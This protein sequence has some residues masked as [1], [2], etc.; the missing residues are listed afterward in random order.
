MELQ[1]SADFQKN[2]IEFMQTS[3]LPTRIFGS[4]DSRKGL[5][6]EQLF[7]NFMQTWSA[8]LSNAITKSISE[9]PNLGI[10]SAK[11]VLNPKFHAQLDE[12]MKQ[13][14]FKYKGAPFVVQF[15]PIDSQKSLVDRIWHINPYSDDILLC[16]EFESEEERDRFNK[17]AKS[18]GF[19][20][21][22]QMLQEYKN[23]VMEQGK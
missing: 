11:D 3:R 23:T 10:Q 9:N 14:T 22:K 6:P 1:L 2:V 17:I 12:T 16:V 21:G 15:E 7:S 18:K 20:N 4:W 8:G 13:C 19:I 5:S